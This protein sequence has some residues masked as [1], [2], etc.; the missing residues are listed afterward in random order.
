MIAQIASST[1]A[2]AVGGATKGKISKTTIESR[3]PGIVGN[4]IGSAVN[5]MQGF[6]ADA[7]RKETAMAAG[8]HPMYVLE[9]SIGNLRSLTLLQSRNHGDAC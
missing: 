3:G 1:I 4:S 2:Q 8:E 5:I 7:M 6:A 9:E